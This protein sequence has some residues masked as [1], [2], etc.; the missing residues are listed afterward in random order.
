M[1][2][3]LTQNSYNIL[4]LFIVSSIL[5][6]DYELKKIS[7]IILFFTLFQ[8]ITNYAKCGLIELDFLI[9]GNKYKDGNLYKILKPF[10]K[11]P[12]NYFENKYYWYHLVLILIITHQIINNKKNYLILSKYLFN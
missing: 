6:P 11:P 1:I 7:L 3:V 9:N 12:V 5:L 4:G 10:F 8:Y 2:N